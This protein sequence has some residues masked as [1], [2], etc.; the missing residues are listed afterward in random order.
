MRYTAKIRRPDGS[1]FESKVD[2][3]AG[4]TS[5]TE[6]ATNIAESYGAKLVGLTDAEGKELNVGSTTD[7]DRLDE[8][9]KDT[10]ER[11]DEQ[12]KDTEERVD[13]QEI[14]TSSP[15]P[16]KTGDVKPRS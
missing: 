9:T 13:K 14:N 4:D 3:T 5:A 7:Q 6:L 1:E 11:V 16:D 8:Q 10:E 2:T 15:S 12:N